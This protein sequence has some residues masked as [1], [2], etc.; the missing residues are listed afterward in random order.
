MSQRT[1]RLPSFLQATAAPT[2]APA[3]RTRVS[4]T[5]TILNGPIFWRWYFHQWE[6]LALAELTRREQAG[7]KDTGNRIRTIEVGQ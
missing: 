3:S 5:P 1:N 7:G 2:D 6:T 4:I